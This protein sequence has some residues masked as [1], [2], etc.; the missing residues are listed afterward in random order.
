MTDEDRVS[1]AFVLPLWTKGEMIM[2]SRAFGWLALVCSLQGCGGRASMGGVE[3]KSGMA[4][5]PSM[6]A[7][8][9]A[10]ASVAVRSLEAE[11]EE[12]RPAPTTTASTASTPAGD[13]GSAPQPGP[14]STRVQ[15][16]ALSMAAMKKMVDIEAR[17]SIEVEDISRSVESV[18]KLALDLGGQLV[19]ENT[20]GGSGQARAELALRVPVGRADGFFAAVAAIGVVQSRQITAKDIGKQYYDATLRLS[21]LEVTL[22]RYEAILAQAKSVEEML[23]LEAELGRLR[24]Q[25]EQVKGEL[26]WMG[27]RAARATIFVSLF[28]KVDAPPVVILRPEAKIFPGLR[29]GY[30]RDLRGDAGSQG[31]VGVALSVGFTQAFS[32]EAGGYRST[33][34]DTSGVDAVLV[35]LGGR[36]Y[37]EYLGNGERPYLNPYLHARAGYARFLSRNEAVVGAGLG[38]E[39]LKLEWLTIDLEG[40]G[41]VLFGSKA[42][43]HVGAEPSLGAS[44]AF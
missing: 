21:N 24:G 31:F 28:T 42:G 27:D 10:D 20:R 22:K 30:L 6:D 8:P 35:T 29:F 39:L 32:I 17:L 19:S 13:A 36:F 2:L 44:V 3:A 40:R 18:R 1:S 23:R 16:D 12:A 14:G 37:S 4:P 26:R 9:T 5:A 11:V 38:L 34:F 43:G 15:R 41:S 7:A 25:I 33:A